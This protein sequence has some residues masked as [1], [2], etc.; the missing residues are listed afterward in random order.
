MDFVDNIGGFVKKYM[1]LMV[2][3]AS[4]I[5]FFRPNSFLWVVPNMN[6][7]LGFIMFGM[8]MTLKRDDFTLIIK[9][10]KDVVLGTL[11]QYIIMPLG[12]FLVVKIFNL[13]GEIA[14]GLILLGACPG[15]VTSNVMSFIAKGDVALSVTFTTIATLLAP[16]VTPSF[17]LLFAGQWVQIDALG[18]FISITKVVIVPI[19]L[20][21]ICHRFFSKLTEKGIRILPSVSGLAMV[22]L[23]GGI[24][25]ANAD[26]L[27][28]SVIIVALT[29]IIHNILGY[30]GGYI[31][32]TKIGFNEEKKRVLSIE[33]GMKN[34]TLA[35][36]LA[37]A[38]FAP[39]A[40]IAPAI[41][42]IWHAFSV[43]VLANYWGNKDIKSEEIKPSIHIIESE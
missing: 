31:A 24:V 8:G 2:L 13:P 26:K 22:F 4:I 28:F 7:I 32:A 36:T 41:A 21:G 29:V 10:P 43:S 18:M 6:T 27:T 16:I 20:G 38:H 15:G 14:V 40:A 35:T 1:S 3:I 23:V 11:A 9:R 17:I 19:L 39:Q 37:M 33:T 34:A 5:A 25:S 12:A 42:G 30:I